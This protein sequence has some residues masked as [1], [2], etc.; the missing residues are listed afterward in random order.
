METT[1]QKRNECNLS[2]YHTNGSLH[3][4]TLLSLIINF[5]QIGFRNAG[6]YLDADQ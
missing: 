6:M 4:I 1:F 5:G 2:G 3:I